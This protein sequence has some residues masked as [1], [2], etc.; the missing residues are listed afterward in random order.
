MILQEYLTKLGFSV[1]E[2]SM[3]KFVGAIAGAGARTAELGSVAIETAAAIELMVDRVARTY[4]TL[5]YMSQ[6]TGQ[7]VKYIQSTQFAFKQIGLS[8][9]DATASIES[10][11]S[12]FR[13]QPW[14][15]GLFGGANTPQQ[16]AGNLGRSGRPY[17]QQVMFAQMLG[18]SEQQLLHLQKY[19]KIE[20]EAEADFKKRQGEA[21]FDP[22]AFAKG[23]ALDFSRALN[24]LESDLGIFGDRMAADFIDPVTDGIKALDKII[25][26]LNRTDYATHGLVT[27]FT[28]L[29][30]TLG[31]LWAVEKVI[32]AIGRGLGLSAAVAATTAEAGPVAALLGGGGG[33]AAAVA[34]G[35]VALP[36]TAAVG[37]GFAAYWGAKKYGPLGVPYEYSKKY[38]DQGSATGTGAGAGATSGATGAGAGA[39]GVTNTGGVAGAIAQ[40]ESSGRYSALGPVTARGDRAY[41]KYQIMGSNIP[42]WSKEAL[43]HSI[44]I[45]EFMA[46]PALQDQI[47][48]SK[49]DQYTKK[50]GASGAARAWLAGEGGMNDPSRRDSYGTNVTEYQRRFEQALRAH[51]GSSVAAAPVKSQPDVW[52]NAAP[53]ADQLSS[54][55]PQQN[56][57]TDQSKHVTL[58]AKTDIHVHGASDTTR[59]IKGY[60]DAHTDVNDTLLWQMQQAHR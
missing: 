51:P 50:Y 36:L 55:V 33:T 23:P 4:E 45:Q 34:G 20:A 2:P 27:A 11:A 6:R 1:D 14:L 40:I 44:S 26:W 19:G 8:A 16:I 22:D 52:A 59:Q 28:A 29:A 12:T 13:T 48:T 18:M 60:V 42:Q 3:K 41:G 30:G 57:D 32:A 43:G 21:G 53:L 15:K 37:T 17:F 35:S 38:M 31:G 24:T 49:L 7:S 56:G 58:N 9:E 25:Q 10:I 54:L 39:G 47:A 5:Y 46:N